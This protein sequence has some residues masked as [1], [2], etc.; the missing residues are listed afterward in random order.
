[1]VEFKVTKPY[2]VDSGILRGGP[3][4]KRRVVTKR[5]MINLNTDRIDIVLV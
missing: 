4:S 3:Y 1:M 5:A 2:T